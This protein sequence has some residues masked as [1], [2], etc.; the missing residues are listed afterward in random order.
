MPNTEQTM[1]SD[2]E[3]NVF[4]R[5]ALFVLCAWI[6][7]SHLGKP[8]LFEPDE[9]RNAEVAREVLLLNDWVTPHYDF[10]PRLDKPA[11]YFD[12]VALSYKIF[13]VSQ[14]SARF[15][16]ALAAF[17][18]LF[19]TYLISR[20]LFDRRVALW[21]ALILLTT[22]EFFILSQAVILDMLLTIFLTL[23]LACFFVG[24]L[25]AD[26]GGGR[27]EFL[28]MYAAFAAATAT[29]GPIGFLLPGLIICSYILFTRQ[30]TLLRRMELSLGIP[31]FV[32]TAVSWY[33]LAESRNPGYVRHFLWEENILR[34]ATNRFHR[35][36]PWYFYLLALSGG[37]LP[38]TFL[39]P[40][41]AVELSRRPLGRERLF[42]ILWVAVPLIF[43]SLSSSKLFHYIL[44]VFPPLAVIVGATVGNAFKNSQA[45]TI[46]LA[47]FPMA[48]YGLLSFALAA[49]LAQPG[50]LP[51]LV[52]S[53]FGDTLPQV[54]FLPIVGL[55]GLTIVAVLG[56]GLRLWRNPV[57]IHVATVAAFV[58]F[59]QFV[60][61][62]VS[63]VADH[64]SSRLLAEKAAR[65]IG[66]ADQLVLF[67]GYPSSL[68][69][70]LDIRQPI[71]VVWSGGKGQV[72]GSDYVA[73][74]KP[75]P[76]P[77]YGQVL[78]T[79]YPFAELW[80]ASDRRLLAFVDSKALDRFERLVQTPVRV[81]ANHGH[82][83]LVES[84]NLN[85]TQD[86]KSFPNS[87]RSNLTSPHSS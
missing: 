49:V 54:P 26:S 13:G 43:F 63:A 57:F 77:G 19:L 27:A 65:H 9:G 41:A 34:F 55:L 59:L 5:I 66:A 7:F 11:L 10:I 32:V 61:P 84:S 48:G 21:S 85:T 24:Q 44:P 31:L 67:G 80:K 45:K 81:I 14:W 28:L 23:G 37:F 75:E 15:P 17:G 8:A 46:R 82:M 20:K 2:A 35:T 76:A 36:H 74:K 56:V 70:Y 1:P 52:R 68:P 73:I 62:I 3:P 33:L 16:S 72:L 58:L 51:D 22:I 29:K 64:R 40:S 42:L 50:I 60:D 39:L 25:K 47:A 69:F 87:P 71:W 86:D 6:L 18:C 30:V 38:W 12:L 83:V 4:W 79:F 53:N 78:Y